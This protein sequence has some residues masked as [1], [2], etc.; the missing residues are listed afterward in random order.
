[1]GEHALPHFSHDM[2]QASPV[3]LTSGGQPLPAKQVLPPLASIVVV[4]HNYGEFIGATLDSISQQ[5]YS[6]FE[7]I[8]VDNA[9]TDDSRAVIERH[10]RNDPRFSTVYLA[11]N[12]GQLRGALTAID[13]ARGGFVSFVDA[14]DVLFPNYLSVH[15]QAHLALP[16]A[17]GVTSSDIIEADEAGQMLTAGRCFF[18]GGLRPVEPGLREEAAALRLSTICAEDYRAL[19]ARVLALPH[20]HTGWPW[21]P[22]TANVYRR[23]LI[24]IARPDLQICRGH[25]GCDNYFIPSIHVMAGSALIF[26]P[27]STYRHHGRNAFS[28][29]PVMQTVSAARPHAVMRSRVQRRVVLRNF[30]AQAERFNWLLAGNRFWETIDLLGGLEGSRPE[31]YFSDPDVQTVLIE[32]FAALSSAFGSTAVLWQLRLRMRFAMWRSFV[33]QLMRHGA[34]GVTIWALLRVEARFLAHRT[35]AAATRRR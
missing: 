14:D 21:A 13:R 29:F 10:I 33:S 2:E 25:T 5:D 30:T 26:Q 8:V 24:D 7:C 12:L 20:W 9:S 28:S 6:S 15:L 16:S 27:L 22:G 18:G 32:T 17:V 23:A 34:A 19:T 11:E 35:R 4:N 1:L 3:H 31:I